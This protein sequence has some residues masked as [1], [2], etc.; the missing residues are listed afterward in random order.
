MA[1][2]VMKMHGFVMTSLQPAS[3]S[4]FLPDTCYAEIA[5]VKQSYRTTFAQH[6][7]AQQAATPRTRQARYKRMKIT[8]PAGGGGAYL[9]VAR[10]A[11][12]SRKI[13]A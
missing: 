9:E 6:P 1:F 13:P 2:G 3:G 11:R 10:R 4:T 7:Q 8:P 12:R 5:W